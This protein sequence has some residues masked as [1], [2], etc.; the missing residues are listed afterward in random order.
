MLEILLSEKQKDLQQNAILKSKSHGEIAKLIEK[1]PSLY[2]SI[3]SIQDSYYLLRNYFFTLFFSEREEKKALYPIMF[4]LIATFCMLWIMTGGIFTALELTL[5]SMTMMLGCQVVIFIPIILSGFLRYILEIKKY[6]IE[7]EAVLA[8]NLKPYEHIEQN[9]LHKITKTMHPTLNKHG[10]A[11]INLGLF[12]EDGLLYS[13]KAQTLKPLS[14]AERK[15]LYDRDALSQAK[16]NFLEDGI[17]LLTIIEYK[18]QER[19]AFYK[20]AETKEYYENSVLSYTMGNIYSLTYDL[21]TNATADNKS[22]LLEISK[23]IEILSA[24]Q[25]NFAI[26]EIDS[27][28]QNQ[29][30]DTIIQ[31]NNLIKDTII[32]QTLTFTNQIEHSRNSSLLLSPAININL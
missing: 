24:E 10:A 4:V 25:K 6:Y 17:F 28:L 19:Q 9:R 3:K 30:D 11:G 1:D 7:Y 22:A 15:A 18:P 16:I 5:F 23:N 13:L 8:F 12:V 20:D 27:F 26:K 29:K 14:K 31:I 2:Y 21:V 32:S